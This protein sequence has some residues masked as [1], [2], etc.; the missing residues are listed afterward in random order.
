M[1]VPLQLGAHALEFHGNCL[2]VSGI[3]LLYS[4][5]RNGQIPHSTRFRRLNLNNCCAAK[6]VG[7]NNANGMHC[8]GITGLHYK[9]TKR[10]NLVNTVV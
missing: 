2:A 6:Q 10:F 5:D 8:G 9:A 7:V 1:Q 4:P 3:A